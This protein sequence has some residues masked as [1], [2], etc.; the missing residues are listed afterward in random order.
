ML[1]ASRVAVVAAVVL[2]ELAVLVGILLATDLQCGVTDRA[3]VCNLLSVTL[4]RGGGVVALGA[5]YLLARHRWIAEVEGRTR[6]SPWPAVQVAGFA[7]LLLPLLVAGSD[8]DRLFRIGPPAWAI[9][10]PAAA[11]GALFWLMG[12]RAWVRFL[13]RDPVTPTLLVL[14]GLV[15]PDIVSGA[16]LA[17][18]WNPLARVTFESVAALASLFGAA[19][20]VPAEY[21]VILDY[22]EVEIAAACSGIQG[23]A[24]TL[25][26]LALAFWI[27]RAGLNF[28][29]AWILVPLGLLASFVLNVVR[30]TMLLV[31]GAR[32]S[33]ELA[34]DG[35]HGHAGWLMFVLLGFGLV[36]VA[37]M[38]WFRRTAARAAPRPAPPPLVKD[39]NAA[40]IVPFMGL[41]FGTLVA[42]TFALVPELWYP[43]R[44]AAT[45]LAVLPFLPWY[46]ALDWT[47]DPV[48]IGAGLAVGLVWV[49]TQPAA[50]SGEDALAGALAAAPAA[51]VAGWAAFRIFGSVLLVPLVEE[52]FFRGYLQQR[53]DGPGWRRWAALLAS[54]AL[55]AMLH[56]RW[57]AG[58]LAGLVFGLAMLRRGRL[59]DAVAAHAAAN[60]VLAATA[61]AQGDWT[62]F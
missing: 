61:V 8:L 32:V 50:T 7:L 47:P 53:L 41:M 45:A 23:F 2:A 16:D 22:F 54:A 57:L 38:P 34:L 6:V 26:F 4:S 24:L 13:R 20:T 15:G 40:L 33:P 25:G 59:T 19:Q 3:F 49:L 56:E 21:L 14:L 27:D 51:W 62:A 30:I 1:P 10:A 46:R 35:F 12:P 17:W 36:A 43:L 9:G 5:A 58:F 31:I 60:L 55:F 18:N 48:A 37:R 11:L 29:R 39:R 42:S 44:I 28:R 52:A